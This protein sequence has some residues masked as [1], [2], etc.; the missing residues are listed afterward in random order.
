M[1][2]QA[3]SSETLSRARGALL[4]QAIGDAL[5]TTVEFER[6][7]RIARQFPHGVR[8]LIGGGP[9]GL[10]PGQIT[11]DTELALAL[12]RSL[13][14]R[15]AY[16]EDAVAGAYS[17][18][19]RSGP[20]DIG[21]TTARAFGTAESGGPATA[22]RMRGRAS[23]ESQANGSL[24]RQSPLGIFGWQLDPGTLADLACR[25]S[26]L[27]HPHPACQESCVA[28]THAIALAVRTGAAPAAVYEQTLEFMRPRRAAG[29]SGVLA[30]LEGARERVPLDF[31]RHMGWVLTALQNAFFRLL[32]CASVEEALVRTV[33][34]GGDTDTNA[35]IAGALAGAVWG[36]SS[37]P[38]RWVAP[39][40]ACKSPRP[41]AY[42]CHDLPQLAEALVAIGA[43]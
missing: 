27:S 22:M 7:E 14:E 42:A 41:P 4:G 26:T 30:A 24:M 34:E 29:P 3:I 6:A 33:A 35:C 31:Y 20:F 43:E 32:H 23:R 2:V 36:D 1:T 38:Q 9:F 11:D 5:G 18:W 37:L 15:H 40:L 21:G 16:E 10:L 19:H 17:A 13:V 25:D 39:L 12:A 28:F 8:N